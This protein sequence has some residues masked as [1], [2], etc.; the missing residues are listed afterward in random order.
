MAQKKAQKFDPMRG[1]EVSDTGIYPT[2]SASGD[3]A[4]ERL[5]RLIAK[6]ASQSGPPQS[7]DDIEERL[8]AGL[9]A[10]GWTIR[11]M[12]KSQEAAQRAMRPKNGQQACEFGDG[13]LG[14][15]D[16][17]P[18]PPGAKDATG[19]LAMIACIRKT[20]P[21]SQDQLM[22]AYYLGRN[23][24]R[25]HVRQFEPAAKH[26]ASQRRSLDNAHEARRKWSPEERGFMRS[27]FEAIRPRC[28]SDR[29]AFM[30]LIQTWQK[31]LPA[32]LHEIPPASAIRSAAGL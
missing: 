30:R 10:V 18:M 28:Q 25:M 20:E 27:A 32:E 15:R 26:G 4:I 3:A 2:L 8:L 14:I 23:V 5:F 17:G 9:K 16:A 6:T 19:A 11:R 12:P 31:E 21:G 13:W 1:I 22:A 24:E 29:R 7:I